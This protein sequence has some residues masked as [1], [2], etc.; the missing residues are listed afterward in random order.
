MSII[1]RTK[2]AVLPVP[3]WA[4]PRTSRPIRTMGMA[5]FLDRGGLGIALVSDCL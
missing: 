2:E 1:G 4:H 5:F 3:V